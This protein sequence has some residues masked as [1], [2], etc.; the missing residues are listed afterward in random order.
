MF[1]TSPVDF[2]SLLSNMCF[3]CVLNEKKKTYECA[4]SSLG[5]HNT[6]WLVVIFNL[7]SKNLMAI[8][9]FL[10]S[11]W[12]M[13]TW[14]TFFLVILPKRIDINLQS[15]LLVNYYKGIIFQQDV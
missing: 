13:N 8:K 7:P 4:E 9:M 15:C 11:I 14:M 12:L 5:W 2:R 3:L 6:T 1:E 10:L